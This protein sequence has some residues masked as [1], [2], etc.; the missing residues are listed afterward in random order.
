MTRSRN[1]LLCL[2]LALCLLLGGMAYPPS[3]TA[4]PSLTEVEEVAYGI[5][6]W[7]KADVGAEEDAPLL[8]DALLALAGTTPGDWY[9]IGLGRLGIPDDQAAYLAVINDN[10]QKRYQTPEK[11]SRAKATEWHRI[12]LAVLACGGNPRRM[13]ESGQIDLVADGTYNRTD[14]NGNGILGRQGINGF[15]FGLIALDSMAYAVPEDAFY[16]RDD[17]ILNL[18]SRQLPD[19]GWALSGEV[20]DPDIT[21]MTIQA[22]APYY[23]SEKQYLLQRP[24]ASGASALRK[25]RDAVEDALACLSGLQQEDGGFISWGMPNSESG[26]QVLVALC[27][28]GIDPFTDSRFLKNGHSVYD[29]ILQYRNPD[30]GFL[31]SFVYDAENPSSLP[32]K[33]NTM[34][35]EQALY[36]MAA[37]LRQ[38]RRMRR[39]YDFRPEQ[40]EALQ[41]EIAAVEA[42]IDRLTL[43]SP[44]ADIQA[45]Y[46]RYLSI[47]STERSYVRNYAALS[48]LLSL[49]GIPYAEEE[50]EYNSGDAGLLQPMQEFTATD[51]AAVDA[52][53]EKLST[54]ARPQVLRLWSK[55]R[56][57]FDFEGKD[58]YTARLEQAKAEIEG[59]QKEI[60]DIN[61]TVREKLYPFD[62]VGLADKAVVDDLVARYRALSPYDREKIERWEDVIK[63]QT[64]LDNLLRAIH[65]GGAVAL[66][67]AG[68]AVF[69]VWHIRTRRR[70]KEREMEALAARY[71]EE[72]ET[73]E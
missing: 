6:R 2:L 64:K 18:L 15:I 20:C 42:E 17:L 44:V 9:P 4:T 32:D 41:A 21:G 73:D 36:G 45:V 25:V 39:L 27:A 5:L 51:R 28:L 71:R 19:G 46:R 68:T 7:K 3:V 70:K 65:I 52:L 57:C 67:A 69:L 37:L 1:S 72:D 53:P 38:Q 12:I 13:G 29:G 26:V 31:H 24:D 55:I 14:G 33:S 61:A 66:L 60:D 43:N 48:R 58:L 11:L 35:G 47:D 10:V 30:G 63:T 34:A 40:S 62:Q 50:P 56:N 59:L 8:C 54:A 22:L 16:T 23:N 49:A